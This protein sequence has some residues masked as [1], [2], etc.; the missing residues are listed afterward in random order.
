MAVV[1]E[2]MGAADSYAVS[3]EKRTKWAEARLWDALHEVHTMVLASGY[4]RVDVD[5]TFQPTGKE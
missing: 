2:L 5:G 3:P 1:L 4:Y